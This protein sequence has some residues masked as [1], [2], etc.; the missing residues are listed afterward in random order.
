MLFTNQQ[1]YIDLTIHFILLFSQLQWI[2]SNFSLETNSGSIKE[3]VV[4]KLRQTLEN[5]ITVPDSTYP[6]ISTG[7][8]KEYEVKRR[9]IYRGVKEM[10]YYLR[11]ELQDLKKQGS[12]G[13]AKK[14]TEILAAGSE[15]E[16]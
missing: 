1:I 3:A 15:H 13:L 7:P 8:K 14:V 4:E 10:W 9:G 16:Q 5:K 2:L 12:P 6:K 11:H